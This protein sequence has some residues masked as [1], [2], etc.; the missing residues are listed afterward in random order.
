MRFWRDMSVAEIARALSLPQKP[1]YRRLERLF[2]ELRRELVKLGISSERAH[3]L[4][5]EMMS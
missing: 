3:T 2:G 4:I 5:S 1:L